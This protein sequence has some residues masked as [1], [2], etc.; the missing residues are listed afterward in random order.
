MPLALGRRAGR[1]AIGAVAKLMRP[2]SG[3]AGGLSAEETATAIYRGMLDREPDPG[4]FQ[5]LV[6]ALRS[7]ATLEYALRAVVASAEFRARMMRALMPDAE[8]PDLVQLHPERYEA[9]RDGSPRLYRARTD[10][11][12]ELMVSLIR[13]HGYYDRFGVW[14]PVIDTDKRITAALVR[15]LGARSCFE[16]GCFTG[17]VLSLLAD[18]GVAAAGCEVSHTGFAFAYPN[19]RDAMVYGDL[20]ALELERKFDVVLCMDVLEH[21]NPL[22]LDRYI[23]RL[24]SLL[25]DDGW[26]YVNSPM[27]GSDRIY[28]TV[29]PQYVEEWRRVGDASYWR[30]WP[31]DGQGWPLHGHLVWASPAWWESTFANHGLVR[32]IAVEQAIHARLGAFFAAATGRRSLFVLRRRGSRQSSSAIAAQVAGALDRVPDVPRP[33]P[34]QS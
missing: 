30:H 7:G 33:S 16:L 18:S 12:I 27:F 29:E 2:R 10:A 13:D 23:V 25:E 11:D 21:L 28:G 31:C 34:D 19:V 17:P 26:V 3:A 4:G 5:G 24:L 32:D 15:G 20:L 22:R 1:G 14:S 6:E 8:L 9:P